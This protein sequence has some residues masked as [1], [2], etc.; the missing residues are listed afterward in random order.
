MAFDWVGAHAGQEAT[1]T[2]SQLAKMLA[3]HA[4]LYLA[5][6]LAILVAVPLVAGLA[7]ASRFLLPVAFVALLL[8]LATSPA[9]RGFIKAQV[10]GKSSW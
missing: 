5:L 4:L 10:G 6:A 2:R 3:R 7:L 8:V 1:M 9:A